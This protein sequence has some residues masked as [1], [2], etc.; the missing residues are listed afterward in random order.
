MK[1]L[2]FMTFIVFMIIIQPAYAYLDPGTGSAII[3]LIIG[4]FVAIGV[5]IKTSCYKIKNFFGVSKIQK[6]ISKN[7]LNII[8]FLVLNRKKIY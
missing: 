5:F 8:S 4:F 6:Q 1:Q 7:K 2:T 3:S